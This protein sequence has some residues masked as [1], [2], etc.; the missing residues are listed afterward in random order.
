MDATCLERF[1]LLKGLLVFLVP[2]LL[3]AGAID[4]QPDTL[5]W[6]RWGRAQSLTDNLPV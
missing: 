3:S 2:G 4:S 5:S 1:H 6:L